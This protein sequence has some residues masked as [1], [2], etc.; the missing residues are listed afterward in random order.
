L[1][2][3]SEEEGAIFIGCA[4]GVSV[5]G[6]I[7]AQKVPPRE[8]F[9]A[10]EISVKDLQGGHS[11]VDIDKGIPNAIKVLA[12]EIKSAQCDI[13]S[14]DGGERINSIPKAARAVIYAPYDFKA[15]ND[16]VNVETIEYEGGVLEN[17]KEIIEMIVSFKQGVRSFDDELKI[18]RVSIN[19]S[20]IKTDGNKITVEFFA[21]AMDKKSLEDLRDETS[22]FL[23]S[24]GF[25]AKTEGFSAPWKPNIT[26]F[27]KKL[28]MVA[29][30]F[31]KNVE[32]K[33]IHAGLE[34]GIFENRQSSLQVASMGPNIY[35]P[36]SLRENCEIASVER[37]EK[38]AEEIVFELRG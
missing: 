10:Y 21:R 29:R 12:D 27:A 4:G 14:I 5:I 38:I 15:K 9:R 3:D 26:P 22:E 2:L 8:G 13:V 34:C 35:F 19:L 18:P 30:K 28:Q 17:S 33:A 25:D 31:F 16:A 1:N 20:T 11:G 32:F 23:K 6:E 36:H 24:F 7:S 37:L